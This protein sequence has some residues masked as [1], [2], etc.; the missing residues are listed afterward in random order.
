[1]IVR[2]AR[3]RAKNNDLAAVVDRVSRNQL[4]PQIHRDREIEIPYA[5]LQGPD[6]RPAAL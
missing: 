6:K 5:A 4:Q 3:V 2:T 1:M